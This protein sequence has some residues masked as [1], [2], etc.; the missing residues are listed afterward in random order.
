MRNNIRKSNSLI[1]S[2]GLTS[3]LRVI[4]P[5]ISERFTWKTLLEWI[6]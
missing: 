2:D 5:Y 4:E 3:Y 1:E 6:T